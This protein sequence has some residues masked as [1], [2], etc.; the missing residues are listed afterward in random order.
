MNMLVTKSGRIINTGGEPANVLGFFAERHDADVC[1]TAIQA[2]QPEARIY[3]ARAPLKT[4]VFFAQKGF[5]PL[6]SMAPS[7]TGVLCMS[8]RP[9]SHGPFPADN[10]PADNYL[11]LI[12]K[13][14]DAPFTRDDF[15][16]S[17]WVHTGKDT[18]E[19][20]LVFGLQWGLLYHH[21]GRYV[22]NPA[23]VAGAYHEIVDHEAMLHGH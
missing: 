17:W 9:H 8:S 19:E 10:F 20:P 2:L 3:F 13:Y 1:E 4:F 15:R 18:F 7:P 16:W 11:H 6:V 12:L 21:I 23:L 14:R 5:G 22:I